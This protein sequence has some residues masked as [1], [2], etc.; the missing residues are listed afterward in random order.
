MSKRTFLVAALGLAAL[1]VP[2]GPLLAFGCGFG[3]KK[4]CCG[5]FCV[6]QYNAFSPIYGGTLYT[7]DLHPVPAPCCGHGAPPDPGFCP[8]CA[9]GY[10]PADPMLGGGAPYT[11]VPMLPHQG[12]P[13]SPVI[14]S[15]IT[16]Q[17][18][19]PAPGSPVPG[20]GYLPMPTPG[21]PGPGFDY[22]PSPLPMPTPGQPFTPPP[23]GQPF[24]PPPP[25]QPFTPPPPGQ[26]FTPPAPG[27]VQPG[28]PFTPPRPSP[29]PSASGYQWQLVPLLP[30]PGIMPAGYY[31]PQSQYGY[32][33]YLP[34]SMPMMP[35]AW[36]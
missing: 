24:T 19:S 35:G 27:E 15:P 3:L 33:M 29:M 9:G 14:S 22:T 18:L 17:P 36:R 12:T 6:R 32:P 5:D 26:P 23:P 28:Q 8:S 1:V 34:Y 30:S 10:G 13:G 7:D 2:T 31:P 25:G 4:K 11:G 21:T 20:P 16:G